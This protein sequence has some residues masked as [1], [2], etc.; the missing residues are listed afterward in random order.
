V[1]CVRRSCWHAAGDHP[2]APGECEAAVG[3]DG[4]VAD[5][6]RQLRSAV[7][8]PGVGR[9][10]DVED[11]A[12]AKGAGGVGRSAARQR[13]DAAGKGRIAARVER[14]VSDVAAGRANV[15]VRAVC[16]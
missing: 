9:G 7:Q 13:A 5:Y 15:K 2:D 16:R 8:M 14:E 12:A 3:G 10:G 1:E 6:S 4:E 11:G